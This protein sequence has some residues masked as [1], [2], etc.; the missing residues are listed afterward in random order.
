M[1]QGERNYF[2]WTDALAVL[3]SH[4]QDRVAAVQAD[5]TVLLSKVDDPSDAVIFRPPPL[6]PWEAEWDVAAYRKLLLDPPEIQV[7]LLIQ[8]GATSMGLWRG[9]EL[10]RHKVIK[11]YV[12]RGKG[13]AQT[14]YLKT[15]GKSRYGSRLRLQNAREH[16]VQTNERLHTW[17]REEGPFDRV[18][19]SCP[20]RMWPELFHAKTLPPFDKDMP[21]VKIARDVKVPGHEELLKVRGWLC[22]G[23]WSVPESGPC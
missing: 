9:D 11:K 14:T 23:W 3:D 1:T 13:K 7:I 2:Y 20:V 4:G 6:L 16:L 5:Q 8:A 10:M 17:W 18:Y 22:N 19:T 15:R 21:R 12:T